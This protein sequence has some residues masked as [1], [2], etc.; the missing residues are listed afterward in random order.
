MKNTIEL[1]NYHHELF[2]AKLPQA[3]PI[4]LI[5]LDSR[6]ARQS[7]LATPREKITTIG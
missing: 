1:L 6:N 4:G 2:E 7:I 3:A 5:Q